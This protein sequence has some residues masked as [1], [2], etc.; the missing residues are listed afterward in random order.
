[1]KHTTVQVKEARRKLVPALEKRAEVA[2]TVS[3]ST[4]SLV[5]RWEHEPSVCKRD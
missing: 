3:H 4:D 2:P 1:V 5:R